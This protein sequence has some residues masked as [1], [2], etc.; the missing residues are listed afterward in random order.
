LARQQHQDRA[1]VWIAECV[2]RIAARL[3]SHLEYGNGGVT[4]TR[5]LR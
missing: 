3:G 4:V 1:P 2:K 5:L